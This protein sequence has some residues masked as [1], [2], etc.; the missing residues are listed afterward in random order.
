M[1]K[2]HSKTDFAHRLH[3]ALD[4]LGWKE[5]GRAKRLKLYYDEIGLNLS[6]KTFQKWLTGQS[7][8][9]WDHLYHLVSLTKRTI[10]YLIYGKDCLGSASASAAID[11]SY[12]MTSEELHS[13]FIST[14]EQAI[15]FNLLNMKDSATTEQI[16]N[17]FTIKLNLSSR[18][19]IQGKTGP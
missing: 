5:R 10:E 19:M 15:A 11:A 12:Y 9:D 4:S 16:F 3:E 7:Y 18:A 1:T 8:P 6:E 17:A 14:L 13:A 2:F